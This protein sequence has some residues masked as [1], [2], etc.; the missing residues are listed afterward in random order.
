MPAR[1]RAMFLSH[2][3]FSRR[4]AA[5]AR[6]SARHLGRRR[7]SNRTSASYARRARRRRQDSEKTSRITA[8]ANAE[9][10]HDDL[11]HDRRAHGPPACASS[12]R[13]RSQCAR[14]RSRPVARPPTRRRSR[15][16]CRAHRSE[17]TGRANRARRPTRRRARALTQRGR[18]VRVYPESRRRT[19][20]PPAKTAFSTDAPFL[21]RVRARDARREVRLRARA[22]ASSALARD[23]GATHGDAR[24]DDGERG[25]SQ[26]TPRAR[27]ATSCGHATKIVDWLS[28]TAPHADAQRPRTRCL[29][30]CVRFAEGGG[31]ACGL[32]AER[33]VASLAAISLAEVSVPRSLL[34]VIFFT[35]GQACGVLAEIFFRRVACVVLI[36][37][38]RRPRRSTLRSDI[39]RCRRAARAAHT[40]TIRARTLAI[41]IIGPQA[42]R[43]IQ[44]A[45][46]SRK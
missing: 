41:A 40:V 10:R 30:R 11:E 31:A 26:I 14:A 12:T 25:R 29:P 38:G 1:A 13:A 4:Y 22:V 23:G 8:S 36:V 21:L 15:R 16:A 45:V 3:S 37:R 18:A 39:A 5:R 9:L 35:R 32:V 7:F 28:L 24:G 20:T 33:L 17:C 44:H 46:T 27:L 6:A 2:S 42:A 34:L 43:V 19:S